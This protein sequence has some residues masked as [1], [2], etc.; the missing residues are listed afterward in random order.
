M[1]VRKEC[2]TTLETVSSG[3]RFRFFVDNLH[4]TIWFHSIATHEHSY[5]LGTGCGF[6]C[7]GD[8]M[9]SMWS[10]TTTTDDGQTNSSFLVDF[11]LLK[12]LRITGTQT[13]GDLVANVLAGRSQF[14]T[15]AQETMLRIQFAECLI[16]N[17]T[18]GAQIVPNT[19][20]PMCMLCS[21]QRIPHTLRSLLSVVWERQSN[22]VAQSDRDRRANR[23]DVMNQMTNMYTW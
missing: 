19:D 4:Q 20:I 5:L 23:R 12:G 1:G 13:N 21:D 16:Q 8:V 7:D 10:A 22:E 9:Q 15:S 6:L 2:H 17:Y 11:G 3:S 18:S 14:W